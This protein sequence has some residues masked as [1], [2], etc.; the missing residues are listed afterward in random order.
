MNK[1]HRTRVL[2]VDAHTVVRSG[3]AAL[4]TSFDD[5]T[6]VGAASDGT[7][8]LRLCRETRPDVVFMALM[9]E[10]VDVIS[11]MTRINPDVRVIVL[12]NFE[13]EQLLERALQAGAQGHLLKNVSAARLLEA[14]RGGDLDVSA[15]S[16]G[17]SES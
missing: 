13:D 9:P 7:A 12:M 15:P 11:T 8:A 17:V 4:L 1:E 16:E 6:L 10:N 2:I 3:L 14:V 5:M